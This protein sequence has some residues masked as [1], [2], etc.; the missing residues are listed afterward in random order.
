MGNSEKGFRVLSLGLGF[1][2]I[3][4]GGLIVGP[5]RTGTETR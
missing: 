4:P 2:V 5:K 1:F 3:E